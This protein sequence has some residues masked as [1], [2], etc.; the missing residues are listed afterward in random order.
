[1]D[2]A[3]KKAI[4]E[5]LLAAKRPEKW[6]ESKADLDFEYFKRFFS[7]QEEKKTSPPSGRHY[8]HMKACVNEEKIMRVLF[9]IL[10]LAYVNNK[11]LTR[12]RQV[13]DILL[14][15]DEGSDRVH[16]FR[17][18]TIIE[19]DLQYIMKTVWGK[20]LM[21]AAEGFQSTAQNCR[22]GRVAQ[23]SVLGH[24]VAMDIIKTQGGEAVII[25]NDAV[26]CYDRILV[27]LGALASMRFGLPDEA[28]KFMVEILKR[29]RHHVV[30]GGHVSE[31]WVESG[32]YHIFDGRGQET[33]WAPAI[34]QAVF[35]IVLTA[36]EKFQPG[37][38]LRSPDGGVE[39]R[40]TVEGHVDDARQLI[41]DEGIDTYNEKMGTTLTLLEGARQA[42]QGFENYLTLTGGRLAVEKRLRT[43]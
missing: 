39:D 34:W 17:N 13:N 29:M 26:N 6:K 1:M 14:R 7:K 11:S 20:N 23:S 41:N 33:G 4:R 9:D 35:D 16:R 25:E 43:T 31:K 22:R 3:E 5:L 36:M 24:R 32:I 37:V 15:K 40:R 38:L 2:P 10:N 21:D 8:G 30:I 18:I 19:G 12:W 27:E 28:A 42:S